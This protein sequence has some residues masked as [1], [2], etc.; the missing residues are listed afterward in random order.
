MLRNNRFCS[1]AVWK[2]FTLSDLVRMYVAGHLNCGTQREASQRLNSTSKF[3]GAKFR[4][5]GL[6]SVF[7][8]VLDASKT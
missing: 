8:S 7:A 3:K 6:S 1:A 4:T 5:R 2:T